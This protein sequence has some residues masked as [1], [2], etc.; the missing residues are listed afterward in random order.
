MDEQI[1]FSPHCIALTIGGSDPSGGAGIQADLKTFQQFGVYGASA[2][3]MLT[4]QNT[5]GV[6]RISMVSPDLVMAQI[7]AV[8]S[9]LSPIIV[10]TGALGNA[11]VINAV[12]QWAESLEVPLIVDPVMVSKSGDALID[13]D[14]IEAYR[15]LLK[16]AT[17]VTPNRFELAQLT[18]KKLNSESDVY[19]AIHD[20]H[21][22][23]AHYVLI[24]MGEVNG[25]SRHIFGSGQSNLAYEVDRI[26]TPHTHGAGCVLAATVTSLLARG[27]KDWPALIG[28]A[29]EQTTFAVHNAHPIGKGKSP[30][31]TR[32]MQLNQKLVA[33]ADAS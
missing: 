20:L 28:S 12:S 32:V 25:K 30:V 14:A 17:L 7:E 23:G 21:K 13:D 11:N 3:T 22:M 31:E 33:H 16:R 8:W 18:G 5:Q 26:D 1:V 29:I 15:V 9:D 2:I 19:D 4:V 27:A 10:K 24:K 6:K